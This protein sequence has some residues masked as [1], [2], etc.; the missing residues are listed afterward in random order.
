MNPIRRLMPLT[1]GLVFSAVLTACG[2]ARTY[3]ASC[4]PFYVL[5]ADGHR[6]STG[7][8]GNLPGPISRSMTVGERF[9]ITLAAPKVPVPEP[10]AHQAVRLTHRAG[11][12]V[13]YTASRPGVARLWA[14]NTRGC[15]TG[16]DQIRSCVIYRITI[17][18]R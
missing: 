8:T 18:G 15:R 12:Q 13:S 14:S 6:E 4:F 2:S 3:N 9:S 7:C 16:F 1:V 10:R 5:T 11:L 17:T